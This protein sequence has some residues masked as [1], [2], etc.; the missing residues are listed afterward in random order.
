[1]LSQIDDEPGQTTV[2]VGVDDHLAGGIVLADRPRDD[3]GGLAASLRGAG[4]RHLAMVTGDR[5]A[6]AE[7]VGSQLGL[8]RVYAERSPEE[9][10]EVVRALR[11][12]PELSPVMMVGDGINDA[13]ALALA[14][15]GIAM[16]FGGA[17]VA[18]E[19]ADAVIVVDRVDRVA[20][21][22]RIGRRALR[23]AVQ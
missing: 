4:I 13:P 5:R 7:E 20:N 15:V 1:G 21:A 14:D 18:S 16:G 19:A 8:D 11:A 12:S 6:V 23:I 17:T 3:A 10:L 22:V 2:L 9:K